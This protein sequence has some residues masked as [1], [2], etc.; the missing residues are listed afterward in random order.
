V[1]KPNTFENPNICTEREGEAYE[2]WFVDVVDNGGS[3]EKGS[4]DDEC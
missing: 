1:S 2:I 3:G 4:N